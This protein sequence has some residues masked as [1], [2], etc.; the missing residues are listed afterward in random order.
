MILVSERSEVA[1]IVSQKVVKEID[2]ANI[3]QTREILSVVCE[4]REPRALDFGSS[5]AGTL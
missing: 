5:D 4:K 1:T 3:Q 2:L